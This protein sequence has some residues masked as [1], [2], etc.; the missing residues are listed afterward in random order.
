MFLMVSG[1]KGCDQED[2]WIDQEGRWMMTA[3]TLKGCASPGP[4]AISPIGWSRRAIT[5][6]IVTRHGTITHRAA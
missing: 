2:R 3:S 1:A 5:L 4:G 6:R